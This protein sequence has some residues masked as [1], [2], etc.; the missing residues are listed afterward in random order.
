[1]T[2]SECL[3]T[4]MTTSEWMVLGM[5]LCFLLA[6]IAGVIE[7]TQLQFLSFV[8]MIAFGIFGAIS[9]YTQKK[10]GVP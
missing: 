9:A 3:G 5:F 7:K 1:M 10:R 2:T 8:A 4:P 6:A